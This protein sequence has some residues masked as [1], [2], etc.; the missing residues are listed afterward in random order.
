MKKCLPK[1][2]IWE[3]N[4]KSNKIRYASIYSCRSKYNFISQFDSCFNV[5]IN[6]RTYMTLPNICIWTSFIARLYNSHVECFFVFFEFLLL[7]A[8]LCVAIHIFPPSN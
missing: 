7:Y 4:R 1:S 8:M 6:A 3:E 2:F 5:L